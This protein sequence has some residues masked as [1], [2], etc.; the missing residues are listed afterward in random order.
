MNRK[1]LSLLSGGLDS[2]LATKLML[3]Q[4]VDVEAVHYDI[5]FTCS[6]RQTRSAADMAAETLKIPLTV[7]SV[8]NEFLEVVKSPKHGYGANINPCID[9]KIFMLKK[10]KE[11]LAP[12]GASFVVTGEVLG[13]RPM[14]QRRDAIMLIEKRSGLK[15]LILRPLSAKHFEPTLPEEKGIVDRGR[16]LD[17]KGRSRKPQMALAK[18]FGIGTYPNPA[19]GCLLTDP[20]FASRVKDMMKYET[21]TKDNINLL[22]VGR[23]FR[24]SEKVRLVVGRDEEENSI[25]ETLFKKGD[26]ILRARDLPGPMTILRGEGSAHLLKDACSIVASHTKAKRMSICSIGFRV[27]PGETAGFHP[28][29]PAAREL[30]DKLRI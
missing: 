26:I 20:R 5:G 13:E 21:L 9:C 14:S 8:E 17:I 18:S 4:G 11:Y 2:I 15:G 25:L 23:H 6:K 19:G 22:K 12:S 28:A 24:L 27:F 16:L 1:A 29:A 3:E 10:A 30:L 7:F